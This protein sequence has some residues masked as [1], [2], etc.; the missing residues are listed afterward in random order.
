VKK[1]LC[2]FLI[3]GVCLVCGIVGVIFTYCNGEN[4]EKATEGM[5][6]IN[7]A[8][9]TMYSDQG[10]SKSSKEMKQKLEV[11]LWHLMVEDSA[12]YQLYVMLPEWDDPLIIGNDLQS[13]ASI[14]KLFIMGT[15]YEM[16]GRGSLDLDQLITIHA[17]DMVGG[18][19]VL[20]GADDGSAYSVKKLL[21]LMITESDNTATNVLMDMIGQD[22]IQQF[23]IEKGCTSS[24]LQRKMM[25]F[26]ALKRGRD[27][28][29]TAADVG[30]FFWLLQAEQLTGSQEMLRILFQQKDCECFPKALP[31]ARI[32][33][34]TGELVGVYH[35][36][37]I[38]YSQGK[39]Y[40][41]CIMS[42]GSQNRENTL[43]TMRM[44]AK[45]V[46][47]ELMKNS[48]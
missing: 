24:I 2:K 3:C 32:A 42:S 18:A 30:R 39:R 10:T 9:T 16:A 41:L 13:S 27:N 21:E 8:T 1:K 33:H 5:Q 19:G 22:N 6:E 20:N 7:I 45:A 4:E 29:T 12:Q 40:I 26:A 25:D 46:D 36:A 23:M 48:K 44:M 43:E 11:D 34:K 14:I 35:D 37:G 17:S 31:D 47:R 28:Y 15:A 38:V